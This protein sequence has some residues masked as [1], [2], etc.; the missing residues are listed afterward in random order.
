SDTNTAMTRLDSAMLGP[1]G[2]KLSY[3]HTATGRAY[4]AACDS[5]ERAAIINR[6]RPADASAGSVAALD[7]IVAQIKVRGYSE[8]AP[9]HPWPDRNRSEVVT[10]GRRSIAVAILVHERAAASV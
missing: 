7:R 8:R 6:I 1:I 9:P 2:L 10:D 3:I 4:L 5:V